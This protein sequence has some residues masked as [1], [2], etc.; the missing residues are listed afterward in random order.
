MHRCHIHRGWDKAFQLSFTPT[1][2]E[3]LKPVSPK[4]TI[5]SCPCPQPVFLNLSP[6]ASTSAPKAFACKPQLFLFR[7]SPKTIFVLSLASYLIQ[8]IA[9]NALLQLNEA[10]IFSEPIKVVS[11]SMAQSVSLNVKT[12]QKKLRPRASVPQASNSQ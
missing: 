9:F 3:G 7:L 10:K 12:F 1:S 6:P 11:C 8:E 5:D 2:Q 4:F